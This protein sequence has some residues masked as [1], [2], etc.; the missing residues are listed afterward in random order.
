M[1]WLHTLK[2]NMYCPV[3]KLNRV[4]YF[5]YSVLSS[6]VT[7]ALLSMISPILDIEGSFFV[8]LSIALLLSAII[9]ALYTSVVLVAKRL[10]S[11]GFDTVHLWWICGLWLVT[12]IHS[13]GEPESTVTYSLVVVDMLVSLWLLFTPPKGD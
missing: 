7:F 8:V 12:V 13:W 9:N 10:R 3:G 2:H 5:S 1:E 6:I 4:E 11:I